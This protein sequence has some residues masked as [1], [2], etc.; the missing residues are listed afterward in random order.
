MKKLRTLFL[1]AKP[2]VSPLIIPDNKVDDQADDRKNKR[3]YKNY[4][5]ILFAVSF[6]QRIS[7]RP[8]TRDN[9]K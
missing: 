7:I 3:P 4:N 9:I 2:Y 8:N 6:T 1:S 5:S